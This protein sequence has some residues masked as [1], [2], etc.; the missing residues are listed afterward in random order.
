MFVDIAHHLLDLVVG[1][2]AGRGVG[3]RAQRQQA[4][5][6]LRQCCADAQFVA[7]PFR[8]GERRLQARQQRGG[9]RIGGVQPQQVGPRGGEQR[10]HVVFFD[11]AAVRPCDERRVK[12]MQLLQDRRA[13]LLR[14]GGVQH[15]GI[16][17]APAA[18]REHQPAGRGIVDQRAALD[19]KQFHRLVPVPGGKAV[20]VA[21]DLAPGGDVGELR[22]KAGQAFFP[23]VLVEL[24]VLDRLHG[25]APLPCRWLRTRVSRWRWGCC[26][27]CLAAKAPGNTPR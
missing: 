5:P 7:G 16:D 20:G 12:D 14:T 8:D 2:R 10:Q 3:R 15:I 4:K 1:G 9:G 17:E 23:R 13:G 19:H 6:Q 27:S 21:A 24:D 26:R 18:G 25:R 22:R 11:T